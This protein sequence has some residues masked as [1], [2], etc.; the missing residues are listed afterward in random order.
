MRM[1]KIEERGAF[2]PLE[3]ENKLFRTF[4]IERPMD[5]VLLKCCKLQIPHW[6]GN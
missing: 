5:Q 3:I 4:L 2:C 6:V 1:D